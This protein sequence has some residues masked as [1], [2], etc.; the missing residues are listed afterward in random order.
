MN[1]ILLQLTFINLFCIINFIILNK[2]QQTY[3]KLINDESN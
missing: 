1:N 3:R 2:D